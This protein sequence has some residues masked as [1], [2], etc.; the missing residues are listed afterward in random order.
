MSR[1]AKI[2][3]PTMSHAI[4]RDIGGR[5]I[6]FVAMEDRLAWPPLN[7]LEVGN[8]ITPYAS[9]SGVQVIGGSVEIVVPIR[10]DSGMGQLRAMSKRSSR[11]A[12]GSLRTIEVGNGVTPYP[13]SFGVQVIDG[14]VE[15]VVPV[16]SDSGIGR[17]RAMQ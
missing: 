10:S 9:S 8:G 4:T 3:R 15:I 5:G 12:R 1:L 11:R 17:I 7:T 2:A 13:S 14:R 16:D 6:P